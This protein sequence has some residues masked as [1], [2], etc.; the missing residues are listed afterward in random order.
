MGRSF[1]ASGEIPNGVL[2]ETRLAQYQK[3]APNSNGS[4]MALLCLLQELT[5]SPDSKTA[6]LAETALRKSV[7]QAIFE[8]DELLTTACEQSLT[9]ALFL[10]SQW[11][12][13]RS[14]HSEIEDT[15]LQSDG[16]WNWTADVASSEWLSQL[17]VH[18]SQSVASQS[19]VLSALP[20]ILSS[21]KGFAEKAFPFVVHL[22]LF[23]QLDQHQTI[24]RSLSGAMKQWLK[25]TAPAAKDNLKLL[26][27][28]VLYLRTQEYPKELS[29]A[30]RAHWLDIDYALAS[31]AASRCGMYKTAL[32]FAELVSSEATRSSRRSSLSREADINDTLLSIFE[33]IDDPDAYYGLPEDASLSKVLARVEYESEGMKSLAFRGAQYDSHL[34]QRNDASEADAQ[35]LVKALNT[36]GLSGLSHSLLQTQQSI[37]ASSSS[38]ENTFGTAQKLEMW[39][40]PAP[41]ESD[42]HAVVIYKA[43]QSMHQATDISLVRSTIYNGFK[44]SMDGLTGQGMNATGFRKRLGALAALTELDDLMNISDPSEIDSILDKFQSRSQWM[45]S[46]L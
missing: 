44:I 16:Y 37:R 19:I 21:I 23:F 46:G 25:S 3:I 8:E 7:S 20:S 17:S 11:G 31:A 42:H 27:N 38:L 15:R 9:E 1:S 22:V 6:G 40:L 24:K 10:S 35:A 39:N 12:N 4:E 14:P 43:F 18:L 45:K 36:L 5:S 32:L 41:P 28:A 26:L 29:I 34:R 33:N 13:Y 2:R 30:D